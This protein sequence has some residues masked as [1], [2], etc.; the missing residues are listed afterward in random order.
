M[1]V[2]YDPTFDAIRDFLGYTDI[3]TGAVVVGAWDTS[4]AKLVYENETDGPP[5]GDPAPWVLVVMTSNFYGQESMGEDE[6][7]DN[8]WDEEGQIWLHVFVPRGTGAREARRI[9][10]GLV[11][12]F[13]GQN[14]LLGG[15]LEFLDA[16]IT[17]EP[18]NENA[19]Y[20]GMSASVEW[21]F[22][23]AS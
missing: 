17:G 15:A 3:V 7:A 6:Q 20:Y 14:S 11:K 1:T 18:S 8:R 19:N 5:A 21:R 22:M 9:A 10:R 12:L 4:I 13:R 23:D 16:S 2:P